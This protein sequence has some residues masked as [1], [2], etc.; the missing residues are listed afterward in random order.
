MFSCTCVRQGNSSQKLRFHRAGAIAF[1]RF[2]PQGRLGFAVLATKEDIETTGKN[3]SGL[4][5]TYF[6]LNARISVR[7]PDGRAIVV[8]LFRVLQRPSSRLLR[9]S[10]DQP[11]NRQDAGLSQIPPACMHA[12]PPIQSV[13]ECTPL[14]PPAEPHDPYDTPLAALFPGRHSRGSRPPLGGSGGSKPPRGSSPLR[15]RSRSVERGNA[16]PPADCSHP[17]WRVHF[18]YFSPTAYPPQKKRFSI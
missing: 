17:L 1:E 7:I 11:Y 16:V 18:L 2:P 6:L 8:R 15:R 9:K 10:A 4:A 14:R 13:W 12:Y 5:C 3:F